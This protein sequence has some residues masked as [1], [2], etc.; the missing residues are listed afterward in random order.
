MK[1]SVSGFIIG[2]IL[3][4]LAFFLT[5]LVKQV[6]PTLSTQSADLLSIVII[7]MGFVALFVGVR[8]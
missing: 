6:F 7:F 5:S 3:L 8:K 2:M 1:G 4:L